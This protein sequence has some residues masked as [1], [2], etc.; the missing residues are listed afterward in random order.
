[1]DV[2][3][4]FLLILQIVLQDCCTN[5]NLQYSRV[6][7]AHLLLLN[8]F[9]FTSLINKRWYLGGEKG[10]KKD[11]KVENSRAPSI[12][13]SHWFTRQCNYSISKERVPVLFSHSHSQKS[14]VF[15][16]FPK[17][18]NNCTPPDAHL[19]T[20]FSACPAHSTWT[21]SPTRWLRLPER[22]PVIPGARL[23]AQLQLHFIQHQSG[24]QQWEPPTDGP[25][26]G[27]CGRSCWLRWE[28]KQA[29]WVSDDQVRK[30]SG[31]GLLFW[32]QSFGRV[33][34]L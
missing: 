14:S 9:V 6:C 31:D 25:G 19:P 28:G 5:L 7:V 23:R 2:F 10:G 33:P 4:F 24:R 17:N 1:M 13:K 20:S 15:F 18:V 12:T 34:S 30:E 16:F 3:K 26:G 22:G 8:L 21:L 32:G 11:N 27:R 29:H